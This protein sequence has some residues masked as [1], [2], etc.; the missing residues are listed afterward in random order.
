LGGKKSEIR[1]YAG[2]TPP[3]SPIPTPTR[4]KNSC[5]K[6]CAMPQTAVMPLQTTSA[7]VMIQV[8]LQ[9]SASIAIGMASVV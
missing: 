4:A 9:R 2:A 6:F 8:R 5:Q 1:E 3:A 7:P